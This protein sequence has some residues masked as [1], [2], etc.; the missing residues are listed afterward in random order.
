MLTRE[1]GWLLRIKEYLTGAAVDIDAVAG[2]G[3]VVVIPQSSYAKVLRECSVQR[4]TIEQQATR[5]R[6]LEECEEIVEWYGTLVSRAKIGTAETPSL[7]AYLEQLEAEVARLNKAMD[8]IDQECCALQAKW[9]TEAKWAALVIHRSKLHFTAHV[10]ERAKR[11][12][13][14]KL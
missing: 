10:L 5:I 11:I 2:E 13:D 9:K 3:Y 8:P 1:H 6:E 4:Q 14:G 7:K 12:I